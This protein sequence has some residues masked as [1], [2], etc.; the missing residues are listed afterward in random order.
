MDILVVPR[1]HPYDNDCRQVLFDLDTAQQVGC[2]CHGR[3]YQW[4][5]ITV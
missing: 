3:V 1:E 5:V 2:T 4:T